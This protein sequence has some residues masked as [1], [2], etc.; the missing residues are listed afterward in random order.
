MEAD[1]RAI[2]DLHNSWIDSVNAGNV[3][4]LLGLMADDAVF[5]NPGRAPFG[6]D[7]FPDGFAAAHQQYRICC[8]S[9]L[10]ELVV[11]GDIAY[12]LCRDSLSLAPRSGGEAMDLAGNRLTIYRKQA[13]G[14]WLLARDANTL[15]L[16]TR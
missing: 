4:G 15:T 8:K 5:L 13:D 2:G 10:E 14:R 3:D 1:E 16:V 7:G 11:A 12:T 6:P 9:E